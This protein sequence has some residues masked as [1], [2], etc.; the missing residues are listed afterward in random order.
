MKDKIET[1]ILIVV[2]PVILSVIV[3]IIMYVLDKFI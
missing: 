2:F 3:G 1:F